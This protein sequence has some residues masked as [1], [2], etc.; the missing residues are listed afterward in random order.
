MKLWVQ[1]WVESERGWGTRPDGFTVHRKLED[2]EMFHLELRREEK[3]QHNGVIPD[4]YSYPVGSPF[5]LELPDEAAPEFGVHGEWA[6]HRTAAIES[7]L[8]KRRS[9]SG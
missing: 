5:E 3:K 2:V 4:V 8:K 6:R 1:E 9:G 7:A